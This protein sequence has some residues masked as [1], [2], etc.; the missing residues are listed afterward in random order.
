MAIPNV[1]SDLLGISAPGLLGELGKIGLY[2][3]AL[4]VVVILWI[5]FEVY[6]FIV[7]RKRMKEIYKIKEDIQRIESK[8]DLV[9]KKVK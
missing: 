6:A 5:I 3:Q 1:S 4:G 9:L 7:R 8:I 2:L